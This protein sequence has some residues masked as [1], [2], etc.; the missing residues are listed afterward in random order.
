MNQPTI[1]RIVLYT[2]ED[3]GVVRPAII[4]GVRPRHET[5]HPDDLPD[6]DLHVMFASASH[7]VRWHTRVPHEPTVGRAGWHWPPRA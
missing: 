4:S 6:L 7:P 2:D 1:G 5:D 3:D